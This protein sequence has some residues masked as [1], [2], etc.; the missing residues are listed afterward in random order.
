MNAVTSEARPQVDRRYGARGKPDWRDIDWTAHQ[1]WHVVGGRAMNVVTLGDAGPPLLLIHG[2]QG[3]WA[4]WLENLPAFA[5]GH[6]VIAPD[7]PGF[8]DSEMPAGEVTISGYAGA[9]AE[10]LAQLGIDRCHVVGHSMGGFVAAELAITRPDLVDRLVLVAAAGLAKRYVGLPTTVLRHPT[11]ANAAR[12]LLAE[13]PLPD[14][15]RRAV[16][17]RPRARV[18]AVGFAMLRP[19]RLPADLVYEYVCGTGKAGAAPAV[20]AIVDYDFADR[21]E[22]IERPTLVVWGRQ[23]RMVPFSGAAEYERRIRDSRVEVFE[24]TGHCPPAER[25]ARFNALVEEFLAEG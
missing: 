18:A 19:D 1:R 16:A 23:D 13:R 12:V 9:L 3:R 5:Q 24:K 11:A 8:G 14:P 25:P 10:L 6:R 7:L 17:R 15:V 20:K 4:H 2:H 21:V 22:E